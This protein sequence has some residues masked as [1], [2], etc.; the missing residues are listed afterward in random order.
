[1][2]ER[3]LLDTNVVID[4]LRKRPSCVNWLTNI[5][6]D[7]ILYISGW[8]LLELIKE[9]KSKKEMAEACAKL[10]QY[11]VAWPTPERC[12]EIPNLLIQY[13]HGQRDSDGRLKG[14][15]IFD[16]LIFVTSKSYGLTLVTM[17]S[18]F[19]FAVGQIQII[20]LQKS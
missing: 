6:S 9:K 19:D 14:N 17:D 1:M 8:T 7:S 13:F 10:Q 20:K 2:T 15:A 3:F 11:T 18:D 16:S 4:L 5:P 12:D